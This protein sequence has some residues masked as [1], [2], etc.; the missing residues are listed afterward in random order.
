MQGSWVRTGLRDMR[1]TYEC[2]RGE[3][4]SG[5]IMW[6][7]PVMHM[8]AGGPSHGQPFDSEKSIWILFGL[9]RGEAV[10]DWLF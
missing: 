8:G 1:A 9:N 7:G 3:W 5:L 4:Y 6:A 2:A 10:S